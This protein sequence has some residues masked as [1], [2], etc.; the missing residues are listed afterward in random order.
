MLRSDF[1]SGPK[2]DMKTG[3]EIIVQIIKEEISDKGPTVSENISIKD[4]E[5]K[6][7]L[8]SKKNLH[9]SKNFDSKDRQYLKT[10]GR[11]VIPKKLGMSIKRVEKKVFFWELIYR[12]RSLARK[13]LIIEEEIKSNTISPCLISPKQEISDAIL[14]KIL[15]QKKN[16]H[17]C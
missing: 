7:C 17:T 6:V 4:G 11:L 12:I 3:E 10:F 16:N 13:S 5:I 8:Y 15:A 14:R 2:K 1:F 9:I